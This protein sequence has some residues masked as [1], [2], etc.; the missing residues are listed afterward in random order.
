MNNKKAFESFLKDGIGLTEKKQREAITIHGFDTVQGM[1]DTSNEGIKEV[2]SVI[3]AENKNAA[4]KDK[5]IIREQIKQ[6]FY[7]ARTEFLMREACGADMSNALITA[8]DTDDLDRFVRKQ[9]LWKEHKEAASSMS[10]PSVSVPKLNKNNWKLFSQAIR[11][12]LTRQRGTHNIPLIYVIRIN[13]A[14]YDDRF[15][16]TEEQLINCLKLSGGKFKS[17]N[18]S[19]WSLLSEHLVGTEAESIVNRFQD[20]RN[21]RRAWLDLVAHMESTSYTDNMKSNAMHKLTT[22]AY[23]GEKKNFGIVKYYQIHSEAHNDLHA[24]GEPLTD[25]MKITHFLQ[26]LRDECAM[27]FAITTKSEAGVHTFEQFYNSFS[28]KLSTKLTLTQSKQ[29][30]HR[31][32]SQIDTDSTQPGRG[33]SGGRSGRGHR[34]GGGRDGNSSRGG[35]GHGRGRGRFGGRNRFNPTGGRGWRPRA[36]EYSD[37]EWSQLTQEQRQRVHDLRHYIR[38]SNSS[39]GRQGRNVSQMTQDDGTTLPSQIG[40]PPPPDNS[41][42][43]PTPPNNSGSVRGRRGRAGDAFS[44]DDGEG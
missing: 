26:G 17:D 11:E 23:T 28:A 34:R 19:V 7:G 31:H 12:L 25:G 10:L 36:R 43:S 42:S 9:N 16:S 22:S 32:I 14:D 35:R 29:T 1:I 37:D 41:N 6:R 5:V 2:F 13:T 8:I 40:L 44:H 27:N 4:A 24:A 33:N 20:T 21:G 3:N 38:E 15:S 30:N 39:N 18:G